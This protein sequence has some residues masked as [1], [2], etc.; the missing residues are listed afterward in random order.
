MIQSGQPS[1]S[2]STNGANATATAAASPA[3]N[4]SSSSAPTSG[5]VIEPVFPA[6]G[7]R[8]RRARSNTTA[9]VDAAAA[10]AA[11]AAPAP[12]LPGATRPGAARTAWTTGPANIGETMVVRRTVRAG[13]QVY[14]AG[15]HLVVI[16]SV[17]PGAEVLADGDIH[18]Y[19]ALRG[20]ALAGLASSAKSR[21]F[22]TVFDPELIAIASV[23]THMESRP[24]EAANGMAVEALLEGTEIKFRP[25]SD[26]RG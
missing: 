7:D 6:I 15:G 13:E 2:T 16:G 23:Y 25:F 12:G 9:R 3:V 8:G 19:G 11:A 14:A 1:A 22:A 4:G 21:I 24:A 26:G 10:A 20:R 17:N 5:P 18:V